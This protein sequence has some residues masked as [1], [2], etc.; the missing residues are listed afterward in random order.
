MP[1]EEE[2][3]RPPEPTPLLEVVMGIETDTGGGGEVR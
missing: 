2:E 3:G 1:E